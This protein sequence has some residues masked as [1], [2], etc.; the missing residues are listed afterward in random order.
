MS[1]LPSKADTA[2]R[3]RHVRLVQKA[4]SCTAAIDTALT[5]GIAG[6]S[7]VAVVGAARIAR[8]LWPHKAAA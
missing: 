2:E 4:D 1:A 3:D 5:T 7:P 8:P 6:F